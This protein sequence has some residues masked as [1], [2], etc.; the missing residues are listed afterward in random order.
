LYVLYIL[1]SRGQAYVGAFLKKSEALMAK[2][3]AKV[4][5]TAAAVTAAAQQGLGTTAED[6]GAAAAAA[7]GGGG[8]A[9]AAAS[10]VGEEVVD[11]AGHLYEEGTFAQVRGGGG[12]GEK[13]TLLRIGVRV[14]SL[15][16]MA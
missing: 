7:G 8:D 13:I 15:L 9:A 3:K 14:E 1:L 2:E 5:A 12:E 16:I 11:P 6:S 4:A 10:G